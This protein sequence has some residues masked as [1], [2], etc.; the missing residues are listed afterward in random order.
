[1]HPA[2]LELL[3]AAAQLVAFQCPDCSVVAVSLADRLLHMGRKEVAVLRHRE[4][5]SPWD[6]LSAS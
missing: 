6:L 3:E 4:S 2:L 1:M 5:K